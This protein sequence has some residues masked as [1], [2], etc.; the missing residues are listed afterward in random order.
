[1]TRGESTTVFGVR[2]NLLALVCCAMLLSCSGW[3]AQAQEAADDDCIYS[4]SNVS[5]TNYTMP[6]GMVQQGINGNCKMM[7]NMVGC[8]VERICTAPDASRAVT[9]SPYCAEF[10]VL[11]ST[12]S[13]RSFAQSIHFFRSDIYRSR[14]ACSDLCVDMPGMSP[15]KNYTSMCSN[16]SVVAECRARVRW[17]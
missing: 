1:M 9:R 16:V 15:C 7:P 8:T 4:P 2:T 13:L 6:S 3:L 14:C 5:C 11:K 10:S 17:R 12:V